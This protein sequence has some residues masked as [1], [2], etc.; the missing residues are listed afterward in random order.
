MTANARP[1]R[2]PHRSR[3][4]SAL[5]LLMTVAACTD[6]VPTGS[7][8]ERVAGDSIRDS[9]F[10]PT[11]PVWF[12]DRAEDVDVHHYSR[13]DAGSSHVSIGVLPEVVPGER[14]RRVG[15]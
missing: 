6:P 10:A 1:F 15:G 5:G 7:D 12:T 14:K 13:R 9:S 11:G 3:L 2:A 4:A 8:D